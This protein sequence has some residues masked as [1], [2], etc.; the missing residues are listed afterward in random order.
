MNI[1]TFGKFILI[2]IKS[3]ECQ[4]EWVMWMAETAAWELWNHISVILSDD[5]N[6]KSD[7]KRDE[8]Q[9]KK[10]WEIDFNF[11]FYIL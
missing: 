10:P 3:T 2:A 11:E 8:N 1:M 7:Y 9:A 5:D 6:N 4:A